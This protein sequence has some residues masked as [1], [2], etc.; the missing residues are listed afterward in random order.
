M[1]NSAWRILIGYP[2]LFMGGEARGAKLRPPPTVN[3]FAAA[4]GATTGAGWLWMVISC[5]R[6]NGLDGVV[7]LKQTACRQIM[8]QRFFPSLHGCLVSIRREFGDELV[9]SGTHAGV[10]V[11]NIRKTAIAI[12]G[13]LNLQPTGRDSGQNLQHLDK[14][15]FRLVTSDIP[16]R[17]FEFVRG[18]ENAIALGNAR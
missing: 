3:N 8:V 2:K 18:D 11:S 9:A 4:T 5:I 14:P 1:K 13:K 7:I 6:L 17:L 15:S 10:A 12:L 16:N